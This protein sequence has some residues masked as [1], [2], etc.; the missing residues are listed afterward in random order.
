MATNQRRLSG[1]KNYLYFATRGPN[2][3]TGSLT[4]ATTLQ[5]GWYKI[6]SKGASS[7]FPASAVAGD[8]I[9]AA[10][11]YTLATG[12]VVQKFTL[13]AAAFVT[14]VPGGKSKEKY[15]N[16]VQ[17]DDDKSYVE[18]DKSEKTGTINGYFISGVDQVKQILSRFYRT[19]E[20]DADTGAATYSGIKTGVIDFFLMR[21]SV[22]SSGEEMIVE[23]MPAIIDSITV[24][25]PMEGNQTLD[26]AYTGIGSERPSMQY[27]PVA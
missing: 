6:I 15:E 3:T 20:Y 21:N 19:V 24:D 25:K 23:Y 18:G 12:D 17:L 2:V 4:L 7:T 10:K 27:I 5:N 9:Y 8:V 13:D 22:N 16:T 26:F 1:Q 11:S 14:N